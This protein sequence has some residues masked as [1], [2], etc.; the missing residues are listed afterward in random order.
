MN[1]GTLTFT[2]PRDIPTRNIYEIQLYDDDPIENDILERIS[3][4]KG[5]SKGSKYSFYVV[6]GWS[7]SAGLAF[8]WATAIGKAI[9]L[10][11]TIGV[12]VIMAFHFNIIDIG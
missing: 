6:T 11:I 4:S 2:A 8:F 10:G 9:L 5:E 3:F 1:S 12:A 7:L